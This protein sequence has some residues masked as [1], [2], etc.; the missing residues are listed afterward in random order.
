MRINQNPFN[1]N[2]VIDRKDILPVRA[3]SE[4]LQDAPKGKYL[5]KS[6]SSMPLINNTS[7]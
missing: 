5:V 3:P 6:V 1:R 2:L 7:K 4:K